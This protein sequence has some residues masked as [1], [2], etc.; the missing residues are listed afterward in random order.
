M[1]TGKKERGEKK[2][3]EVLRQENW[4]QQ[5]RPEGKTFVRTGIG[6]FFYY[7]SQAMYGSVGWLAGWLGSSI[8]LLSPSYLSSDGS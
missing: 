2:K 5:K 7:S 1:A 3:K 8:S 6:I 4:L